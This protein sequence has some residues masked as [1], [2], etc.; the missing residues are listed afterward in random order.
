MGIGPFTFTDGG[1][2]PH[3]SQRFDGE[4]EDSDQRNVKSHRFQSMSHVKC[5]SP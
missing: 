5:V 4:D 1:S 3:D 2:Q